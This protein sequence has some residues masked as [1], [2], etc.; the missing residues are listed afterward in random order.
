MELSN[1]TL[2]ALPEN[3]AEQVTPVCLIIASH[4]FFEDRFIYF[5]LS[6]STFDL[7]KSG[8]FL[9]MVVVCSQVA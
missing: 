4:I 9:Q 1:S 7:K 8:Q 2:E 3:Y 5:F 6:L